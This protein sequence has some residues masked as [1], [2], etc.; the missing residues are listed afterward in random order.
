M[1]KVLAT[2][3][4]LIAV[5]NMLTGCSTQ[6]GTTNTNSGNTSN[7]TEST[8]AKEEP[9]SPSSEP[10]ESIVLRW[11]DAATEG[12]AEYE[13]NLQ[14]IE[15]VNKYTNGIVTIEYYPA[16]Q[17]GADSDV[18]QATMAGTL[19]MAKCSTANLSEFTNIL[20]FCDFP[21]MFRDTDHI[22]EVLS[23]D[24]RYKKADEVYE[25]IGCY[26]ITF[27]VDGGA[28]RWLINT[29]REVKVPEDCSKLKIRTTGSEI[30]MAL[31]NVW[32]IGATPMAW[33]EL[34]TGLQQGTVDGVYPGPVPAYNANFTEV[35]KYATKLELSFGPS[36][37]LLS[38][39]A[40]ES[41]GGFDGELFKAVMKA[42]LESEQIKRELLEASV[43]EVATLIEEQGCTIYY[44]TDEEKALWVASANEIVDQFIGDG[45]T[46]SMEL[47][48]E[49]QA[50]GN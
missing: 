45:K 42:S 29:K 7:T 49:V 8:S 22:Y 2:I 6:S 16:G 1:K 12:T 37:R 32:G 50:I 39:S 27:D 35:C 40:I 44:P 20:D 21:G 9:S 26:P 23:S 47:F 30:E 13:A 34:Y 10:T 19:E 43:E 25:T 17:L 33:Q 5:A 31:F 24:L 41:L 14:F 4:S 18:V 28:A 3:L 15:L 11:G 36:V 48:D 46:I 38:G